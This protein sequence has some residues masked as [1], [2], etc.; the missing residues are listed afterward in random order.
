MSLPSS[1][2]GENH[3]RATEGQHKRQRGREPKS[4]STAQGHSLLSPLCT[5]ELL[6]YFHC[7]EEPR[8]AVFLYGAWSSTA[9][10]WFKIWSYLG[11]I[12]T[13]LQLM[14]ISFS[15]LCPNI[16][17]L[18]L[19]HANHHP[20]SFKGG[21]PLPIQAPS[22]EL[23][24]ETISHCWFF[25]SLSSSNFSSIQTISGLIHLFCRSLRSRK[26]N[27]SN[28]PFFWLINRKSLRFLSC[29]RNWA[30]DGTGICTS[31]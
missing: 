18:L 23:K 12:Q 31:S 7:M 16:F 27:N 15:T 9:G 10:T 19:F 26:K 29:K 21:Q 11:W 8:W 3:S 5:E 28:K 24:L 1:K 25:L 20:L 13:F 17:C 22:R 2:A 14:A 4:T 30:T 6:V